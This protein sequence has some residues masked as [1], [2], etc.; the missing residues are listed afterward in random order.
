MHCDWAFW[1]K[2]VEKNPNQTLEQLPLGI[3]QVLLKYMR[4]SEYSLARMS[5]GRR[6]Y[7]C[8]LYFCNSHLMTRTRVNNLFETTC[9]DGKAPD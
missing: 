4:V 9:C 3:I 2:H 7:S 5:Y 6:C 8:C 1:G